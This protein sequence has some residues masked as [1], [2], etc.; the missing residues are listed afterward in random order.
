[1]LHAMTAYLGALQGDVFVWESACRPDLKLL[2]LLAAQES[3]L[4]LSREHGVEVGELL[5]HGVELLTRFEN[6]LLGDTLARVGKDTQRKLGRND[7]LVGAYLLAQKHGVRANAIALGIAAGLRFSGEDDPSS[8]EAAA[9]AKENGAAA[10]LEKY[11]GLTDAA[12]TEPV[13]RY[14]AMLAEHS[15][16][17]MIRVVERD[18]IQ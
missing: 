7:R 4:A 11:S 5:A 14:Y 6:K 17:D 2:T 8:A 13:V 1:M 10:A 9:Y 15:L 3:A 18:L 16:T 12:L